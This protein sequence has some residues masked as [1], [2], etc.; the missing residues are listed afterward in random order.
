MLNL[1]PP[2]DV[3]VNFAASTYMSV[4]MASPSHSWAFQVSPS[5]WYGIRN[6]QFYIT[7]YDNNYD[8]VIFHIQIF[9]IFVLYPKFLLLS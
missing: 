7:K 3:L 6:T 1:I 4:Q 5:E 8:Q 9:L 2:E